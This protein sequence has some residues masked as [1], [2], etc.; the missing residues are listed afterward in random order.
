M[1]AKQN[2]IDHARAFVLTAYP[3]RETSL[4]I[5]V[6]SRDYGRVPL[7]ARSARKPQSALRGVLMPFAPLSISWFGANE[8]RTLHTA[9]WL[10]GMP[11]PTNQA[12]L[13]GFYI[14]E[15]M[16]KLTAR[17]DADAALFDVFE[18]TLTKLCHNQNVSQLLREFEWK[19]LSLQGFIPDITVDDQ[20]QSIKA[21]ER[22]LMLPES[23]PMLWQE[24]LF[25]PEYAVVVSGSSL[26]ALQKN[27]FALADG[28]SKKEFLQLNRMLLSFRL[29]EGLSSRR[30]M[31]QVQAFN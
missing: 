9:H 17:D 25:V 2:R 27:D 19:L 30:L 3:W 5:E 22:Y 13:A 16:L 26:Q 4:W 8:L 23:A 28:Q 29:P 24:G 12:L 11:Q 21:T 1:S 31:M 6:F 15:L 14:N 10:G 18:D 20:G 7:L